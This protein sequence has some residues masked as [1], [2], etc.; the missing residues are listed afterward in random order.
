M[1]LSYKVCAASYFRPL[2]NLL[3]PMGAFRARYF[4]LDDPL[5]EVDSYHRSLDAL[6][7]AAEPPQPASKLTAPTPCPR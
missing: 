5:A 1:R 3:R 2:R 7:E 4:L 6:D